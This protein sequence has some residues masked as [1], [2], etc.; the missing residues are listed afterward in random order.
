MVKKKP[1]TKRQTKS[2]VQL[3]RRMLQRLAA[4]AVQVAAAESFEVVDTV[5]VARDGWL[6]RVDREGKVIKRVKRLPALKRP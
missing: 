3:N 1:A 4:E 2:P 5:L 6:V